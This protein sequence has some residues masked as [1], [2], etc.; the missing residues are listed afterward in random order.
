MPS[1]SS[2]DRQQTQR[3]RRAYPRRRRASRPAAGSAP[4]SQVWKL[5]TLQCLH[6]YCR[7]S[8]AARHL[9]NLSQTL[10]RV[11]QR[12]S[13][14]C[15]PLSNR[16]LRHR[17]PRQQRRC[18][19]PPRRPR[20]RR[21]RARLT[22]R[23]CSPLR[24]SSL[25]PRCRAPRSAAR[26]SARPRLPS[27][28]GLVH[29]SSHHCVADGAQPAQAQRDSRVLGCA[30]PGG[31]AGAAQPAQA[32]RASRILC[33]AGPGGVRGAAEGAAQH[34]GRAGRGQVPAP[35]PAEQADPGGG[36]GRRGR[37]GAAAGA[38]STCGLQWRLPRSYVSP[39]REYQ[40]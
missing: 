26:L 33:C 27:G 32:Q 8:L 34:P 9:S 23:S 38:C 7:S 40:L 30:R 4:R 16:S 29:S 18:T 6:L 3:A 15:P 39:S 28:A 2:R 21:R 17:P 22:R 36:C 35:A 5:R 19:A 12:R 10:D 37:R 24:M 25:T 11:A 14:S 20:P 1:P 13:A 31:V